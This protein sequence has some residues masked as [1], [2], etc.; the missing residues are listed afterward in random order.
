MISIRY[1]YG[2]NKHNNKY[3]NILNEL[4]DKI[5]PDDDRAKKQG[6]YWWIAF[7]KNKEP[8]GFGGLRIFFG[9]I[10]TFTRAGVLKEYRGKGIHKRLIRVREKMARKLGIQKIVTYVAKFNLDSANNL[11]KDGF[12][13]YKPSYEYG[14]KNAFY[15]IKEL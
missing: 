11:I 5:F 3:L 7:N 12:Q 4:D 14:L 15:L 2:V 8:I 9:K 6:S 10:A 1:V 13:L